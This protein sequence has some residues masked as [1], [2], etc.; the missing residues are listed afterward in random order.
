[1]QILIMRHGEAAN[2]AGKDSLRPLTKQGLFEAE[3]MGIWLA[4]TKLSFTN[5]FVSPYLR[6]QQTCAKVINTFT[7]A[8]LCDDACFEKLMLETLTPETLDFI[9][10]SGNARQAHD[11]LDGLFQK[12]D[13]ALKSKSKG[14]DDCTDEKQA[15]LLVSH[16]PFVSYLV[17]EL[18][19]SLHTPMFSTGA[20]VV[21][22]YDI[23]QMQG[24]LIELVSPARLK[25]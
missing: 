18:T 15:I 11:F 17:A 25:T 22:D 1:M 21:I 9:T 16:M 5:V 7:K 2:V 12:Y 10:P 4:Q 13:A 14:K 24:R 6:A 23:K 20:I 3:K 19:G 8:T